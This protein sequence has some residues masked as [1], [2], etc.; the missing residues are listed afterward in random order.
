MMM[1][2]MIRVMMMMTMRMGDD[3]DGNYHRSILCISN[4][5]H[6]LHQEIR[7]MT[8]M[9]MMTSTTMIM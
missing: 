5:T 9:M 4:A 1:M 7:T 2:M 3:G 6:F 8:I